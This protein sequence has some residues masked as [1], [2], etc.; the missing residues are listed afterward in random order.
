MKYK[1]NVTSAIISVAREKRNLTR[2]QVARHLKFSQ[3]FYGRIE[4]GEVALPKRLLPKL[5]KYLKINPQKLRTV[6]LLD[7]EFELKRYL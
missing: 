4:K 1:H 2:G 5:S 7:Y 3:Q 6:L